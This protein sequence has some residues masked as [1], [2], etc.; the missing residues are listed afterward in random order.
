MRF[1]KRRR[2]VLDAWKMYNV[3]QSDY[4]HMMK[5]VQ[6]A[7]KRGASLPVLNEL[8]NRADVLYQEKKQAHERYCKLRL[9]YYRM[10]RE[11]S[12]A[13]SAP[14][15]SEPVPVK[16]SDASTTTEQTTPKTKMGLFRRIN[17][18]FR[19]H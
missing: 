18:F 7:V 9:D 10:V 13:V 17:E 12:F 6:C 4:N 2:D 11:P 1:E 16:R 15:K 3:K 5:L 8:M 19:S 14:V